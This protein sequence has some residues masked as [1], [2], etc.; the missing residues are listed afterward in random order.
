MSYHDNKG[1]RIAGPREETYDF[2]IPVLNN[3][4]KGRRSETPMAYR[5]IRANRMIGQGGAVKPDPA[6]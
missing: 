6:D 5:N 2:L 4:Q 3:R 1:P